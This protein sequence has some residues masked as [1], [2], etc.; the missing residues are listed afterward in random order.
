V[1]SSTLRGLCV[2][3]TFASVTGIAAS[4]G[5]RRIGVA[6]RVG[7]A[8]IPLSARNGFFFLSSLGFE[9]SAGCVLSRH[10]CA[11]LV[12]G[13]AAIGFAANVGEHFAITAVAYQGYQI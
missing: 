6:I 10:A 13:V 3:A 2:I 8:S 11:S 12:R 9:F 7:T 4:V 1:L 5:I